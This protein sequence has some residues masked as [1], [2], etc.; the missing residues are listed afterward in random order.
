MRFKGL[1]QSPSLVFIYSFIRP[2]LMGK[3]LLLQILPD[4]MRAWSPQGI[5]CDG[6]VQG[7]QAE[8][9]ADAV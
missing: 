6:A 3:F 2:W 1:H 5:S 9:R 4:S 8:T 7:T